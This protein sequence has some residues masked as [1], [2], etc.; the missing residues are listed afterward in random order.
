[1]AAESEEEEEEEGFLGVARTPE[2]RCVINHCQRV[3]V[4]AAFPGRERKS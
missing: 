1:M 4:R 2:R 3:R